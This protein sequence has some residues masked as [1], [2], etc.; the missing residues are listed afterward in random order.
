MKN[1]KKW[2]YGWWMVSLAFLL[3]A[4]SFG[5][6]IYSYSV[7]SVSLNEDFDVSRFQ[8]ML[9]LTAMILFGLLIAPLLGPKLDKYPIKWFLFAGV[10][11]LSLGL[12]LMSWS[13]SMGWILAIFIVL[14]APVQHLIGMLCCSVLVSRWFV[15]KLALAMGLAAIGTSVGGFIFPPLIEWLSQTYGWREPCVT[16]VSPCFFWL[17]H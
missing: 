17:P 8:L 7:I 16:W 6:L 12:L 5:I 4:L 2:F 14:F 10:L 13:P 3:Q 1:D 15:R 11:L 9:P